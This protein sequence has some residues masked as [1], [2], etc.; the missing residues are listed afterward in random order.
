[1][2]K[3]NGFEIHAKN[4][5]LT[6]YVLFLVTVAMFYIES[7]IPTHTCEP[8]SGSSILPELEPSY[9]STVETENLLLSEHYTVNKFW[10]PFFFLFT[11]GKNL[12]GSNNNISG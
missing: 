11:E 3:P 6:P 7:K 2:T 5:C 1:M 12:R 4:Y 9:H 10:T 8:T